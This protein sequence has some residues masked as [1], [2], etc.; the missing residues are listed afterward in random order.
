M[1][2]QMNARGRGSTPARNMGR[3][4]STRRPRQLTRRPWICAGV[5][6]GGMATPFTIERLRKSGQVCITP[7]RPA[8]RRALQSP[9][10]KEGQEPPQVETL[11]CSTWNN[12][13]ESPVSHSGIGGGEG[14][15]PGPESQN[16]RLEHPFDGTHPNRRSIGPDR[17]DV[18]WHGIEQAFD[19]QTFGP[20]H[21][22]SVRFQTIVHAF[23]FAGSNMRSIGSISDL[24]PYAP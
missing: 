18:R 24:M 14:E 17:T 16:S 20:G 2:S 10:L 3:V 1:C 6:V 15:P 13:H 8:R 7:H 19:E 22:T 23:G 5:G 21:R 4:N 9:Y 12:P 11:Q